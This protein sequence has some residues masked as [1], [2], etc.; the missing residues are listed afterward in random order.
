MRPIG[1]TAE[2]MRARCELCEEEV[3][4]AWATYFDALEY[5][6]EVSCPSCGAEQAMRDRRQ[7]D[8]PVAVD[9]RQ[10]TSS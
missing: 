8:E 7:R 5:G 4:I 6:R 3:G 10:A 1:W 2:T 9:R